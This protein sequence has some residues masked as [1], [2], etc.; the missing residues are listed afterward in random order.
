MDEP[1]ILGLAPDPDSYDHIDPER[2]R[3]QRAEAAMRERRLR[4][5][6]A[7]ILSTPT[8]REWLWGV[9][10]SLSALEPKISMSGTAYENGYWNGQRDAG[11]RLLQAFIGHSPADFAKMFQENARNDANV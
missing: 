5:V 2:D 10:S 3:R 8:G 9:L 11:L 4:D 6:E 7:S 1:P